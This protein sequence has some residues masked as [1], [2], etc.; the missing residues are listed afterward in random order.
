MKP[1]WSGLAPGEIPLFVRD[2]TTQEIYALDW[3]L[4]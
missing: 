2:L 1:P 4:P 3:Q